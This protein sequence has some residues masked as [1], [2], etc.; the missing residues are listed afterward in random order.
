M[1]CRTWH[2]MRKSSTEM[3]LPSKGQGL[4]HSEVQRAERT[5]IT[6]KS[7]HHAAY[8][9]W[10]EAPRLEPAPNQ[11]KAS[12]VPA[13]LHHGK[14]HKSCMYVYK[15]C[16]HNVQA[17]RWSSDGRAK[18]MAQPRTGSPSV[19]LCRINRHILQCTEIKKKLPLEGQGRSTSEAEGPRMAS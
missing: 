12:K 11:R 18:G 4:S 2:I 13:Y 1:N 15:I 10:D 8:R 6:Y 3:K 14:I 5:F 7:T 19:I 16:I 17:S 9:N